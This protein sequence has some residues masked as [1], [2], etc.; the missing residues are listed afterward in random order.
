[1]IISV[2]TS[3][4]ETL[5]HPDSYSVESLATDCDGR[6]VSVTSPRAE[7][8]SLIGSLL[9]AE[10]TILGT[11]PN[12]GK[13]SAALVIETACTMGFDGVDDLTFTDARRI[14]DAAIERAW[15]DSGPRVKKA[16]S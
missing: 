16:A 11:M 12:A 15:A 10:L 3:A 13:T 7:R 4:I 8:F 9:R 5:N 2:L 6:E 14:L 1:M